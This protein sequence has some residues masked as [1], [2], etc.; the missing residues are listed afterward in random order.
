MNFLIQI[1]L[2]S[3]FWTVVYMLICAQLCIS[4][5]FQAML[6]LI[7]KLQINS[8][9]FLRVKNLNVTWSTINLKKKFLKLLVDLE[10]FKE[11]PSF[12]I[13]WGGGGGE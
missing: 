2:I 7:I 13:D 3:D 10:L 12:K 4:F 9:T 11:A 6:T 1:F 5:L 8:F